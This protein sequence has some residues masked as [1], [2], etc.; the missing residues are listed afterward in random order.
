MNSSEKSSVNPAPFEVLYEDDALLAIN[1]PAW[2]VV[3]RG[4][5]RDALVIVDALKTQIQRDMV[6]PLHRLDRQTSGVLLFARNSGIAREM[7]AQFDTGDIQKTYLA[8]VRGIC[9]EQ[10]IIDSPVPGKEGG[11]RV[12]AQTEFARLGAFDTEPRNVSLVQAFP[13]TGRFHQIRRHLKHI[14]HPIIGDSNYGKG[15][16][17]RAFREHYGLDRLALHAQSIACRHPRTG[18]PITITAPLP[19]DLLEPFKK[20]EIVID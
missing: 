18:H 4:L 7:Q 3:H 15:A 20:M 5:A 8:L 11:E 17:N 16:L 12:P 9:P 10:G 1:K 6:H 14:N 2:W 19:A 13:R